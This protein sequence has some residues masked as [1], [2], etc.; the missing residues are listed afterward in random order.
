MTPTVS[1]CAF[2][3]GE[4][5]YNANPFAPLGCKVEAHITPGTRE[6]WE[7]H[8]ARGFYIDNAWEHYRCHELY[9]CD[10][11]HM[12]TCLTIF[13][14]HKYLTMPIVTPADALIRAADSLTDDIAGLIPT[15]TS[16]MDAV[17]QLMVIFKQQACAANDAATAQRVLRERAQAERVIEEERQPSEAQTNKTPTSFPPIPEITGQTTASP[18]FELEEPNS[19][20]ALPQGIPQIM[21][22]DFNNYNDS[23]AANTRQLRETRSLT[24]DFML[25]CMEIPGYKAPFTA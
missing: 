9:I 25:H 12:R 15:L 5:D 6:T 24:Q 16:T 10:T 13:F 7:P 1:A 23:T 3:W 20:P 14:K 18:S 19:I 21:Q 2:L 4:H 17:D 22:D 8:T 11:K